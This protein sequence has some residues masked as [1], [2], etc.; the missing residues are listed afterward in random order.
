MVSII[1]LTVVGVL[2]AG[3][4]FFLTYMYGGGGTAVIIAGIGGTGLA[5]ALSLVAIWKLG[6]E[7][8]L[9]LGIEVLLGGVLAFTI[10]AIGGCPK[11][12]WVIIECAIALAVIFWLLRMLLAGKLTYVKTPLNLLLILLVAYVFFQLLP[13]PAGILRAF[14]SNTL[15]VHTVGPPNVPAAAERS[16]DAGGAWPI[17]LCRSRTRD[18]L[19]LVITYV[20]FF[21]VFINNVTS[22]QQ[23]GRLL[24]VLLTAGAVVVVMGF[25]TASQKE[26][27]YYRVWPVGSSGEKPAFLNR[28]ANVEESA[29]YGFWEGESDEES[30]V[31]NHVDWYVHKVHGGDVFAGYPNSNTAATAMV[32]MLCVALGIGFAYLATRRTE[33]GRSGGLLYT[34]EG[35]LTLLA[36]FA[37]LLL[38]AGIAVSKSR[39]GLGVMFVAVP[40]LLILVAFSRSWLRGVVTLALSPVVVLA[41]LVLIFVGMMLITGSWGQL[42]SGDLWGDPVGWCARKAGLSL[43][44]WEEQ[45]RQVGRA[46]TWEIFGDFR[47]FG[48]GLG[49]FGNV[50][51]GY[52]HTG[53]LLYFA[54]CDPV[55]WLAETGLVG[56][57]LALAILGAGLWTV[58]R[59]L[60]CLK[61]L[62]F[63]RLLLGCAVGCL[64]F[65]GHGLIDYPLYV[66]GVAIIFVTL[67]GACV[68]LGNDQIARHEEDDFIF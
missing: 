24:G 14:Q 19:Y 32:M 60:M 22:R 39:G 58:V 59:G 26:A 35:N 63:R 31:R 55:Q 4:S 37:A 43:K 2:F 48:T 27:N 25:A 53:R 30:T 65:L 18:A 1:I 45:A 8:F 44:P 34:R 11:W 62:F 40:L 17:S 56:G 67:G 61:D 68:V 28:D 16:L 29:G 10:L 47:M 20:C 5:V 36:L 12:T 7:R 46:A 15:R 9:K 13:M 50:Y 3:V 51:P 49:T 23:L 54:H 41:L 52:M 33:W 6:L 21:W 42:F 38:V 57:A 64:A 66:P